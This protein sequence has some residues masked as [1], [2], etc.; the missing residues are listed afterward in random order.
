MLEPFDWL[1]RSRTGAELLATL[2]YLAEGGELPPA[3]GELGPP[4]GALDGPCWRCWLY[5]RIAT[6]RGTRYCRTC[7]TIVD[8]A[9]RFGVLS[10]DTVVVWGFVNRLP[11]Q[12][13]PLAARPRREKASAPPQT[14]PAAEMSSDRPAPAASTAEGTPATTPSLRVPAEKPKPLDTLYFPGTRVLGAYIPDERH[15]LLMLTQ[16]ELRPW[17]QEL[18]LRYGGELAGLIQ[19]FPTTGARDPGM[20]DLLAYVIHQEARYPMD[21]LRVRFFATHSQIFHPN[22]AEREGV[23]TFEIADFMNTLELVSVFRSILQPDEQR[24]LYRLLHK[25]E[26]AETQFLWGRFLGSLRPEARDMLVAF[27]IRRWSRPQVALLYR[28]MDYVG[29]RPLD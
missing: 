6:E 28:L 26:S 2:R 11:P 29:F 12:L 10:P 27:N 1:R 16:R 19:V 23:L 22:L 9:R 15:F 24:E 20:G 8:E 3:D 13:R 4:A 25:A 21:R 14:A 17:L 5:P 18:V 7:Q